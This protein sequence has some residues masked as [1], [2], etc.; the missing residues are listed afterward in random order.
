[1]HQS[2]AQTHS[3]LENGSEFEIILIR[4]LWFN[5]VTTLCSDTDPI[6]ISQLGVAMHPE[7]DAHL[8]KHKSGDTCKAITYTKKAL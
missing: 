7:W 3:M 8:P 4:E 1:M 5:I 6:G 2:N